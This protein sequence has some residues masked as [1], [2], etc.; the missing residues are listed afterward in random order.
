MPSGWPPSSRR[1]G[2][3]RG[4]AWLI[5]LTNL[6]EDELHCAV[7]GHFLADEA[8][9][10]LCRP[11]AHR[12]H[13]VCLDDATYSIVDLAD[14]RSRVVLGSVDATEKDA[15]DELKVERASC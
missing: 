5:S 3:Q 1:G 7:V 4:Y 15:F 12:L 10:E 2:Q 14:Q 13:L 8:K 9:S 11:S 6:L